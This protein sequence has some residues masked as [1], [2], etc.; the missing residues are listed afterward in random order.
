M[1]GD[2]PVTAL[3]IGRHLGVGQ[4]LKF[5]SYQTLHFGF[6]ELGHLFSPQ[7]RRGAQSLIAIKD[8]QLFF[9]YQLTWEKTRKPD[10]APARWRPSSSAPLA[11]WRA[12][13]DERLVLTG[14]SP[15]PVFCGPK[16]KTSDL[17]HAPI[18]P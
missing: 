1:A 15:C 16:K 3:Y 4:Q 13:A 10:P 5:R 6:A 8:G 14:D 12:P 9:S 18:M 17:L 7:V 11:D 2:D